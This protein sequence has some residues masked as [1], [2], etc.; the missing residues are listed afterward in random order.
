MY[1]V[2]GVTGRTGAVAA[3]TLIDAGVPVRVVV[4][5]RTKAAR[6]IAQG[7]EVAVADLADS[8]ALTNAFV[9]ARGAYLV[10]PPNYASE[11][12]FEQAEI[13]S[14]AVAK[15]VR[16]AGLPKVVLLSSVGADRLNGTGVIATNRVAEQH[17]GELG[18][19][20][21]FLRAAY[22]MEN[23]ARVAD[24]V[25][26]LGILPSLLV[27]LDRAIP[28]VSTQDVG[29]VAAEIL[30]EDWT[31]VRTIGLD[32]PA[33]Y[34]PNDVADIFSQILHRSVRA[35]ALADSEW[36]DVLAQNPFSAAAIGGF[37]EL[38]HGLNSGHIA[39]ESD[40]TATRRNGRVPLERAAL[41]FLSL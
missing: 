41:E 15:A 29:R 3:Q 25:R 37:I 40:E 24:S 17:L 18:I 12:L 28:M 39:F 35:Q 2:T 13:T 19:P 27:P 9:G 36:A 31:G 14:R 16:Q 33:P 5:D 7:A 1:V 32:G 26:T 38:N 10:K 22:F 6:W 20:V 34:S 4:R 23:W 8:T 11:Y 30:R 21:A